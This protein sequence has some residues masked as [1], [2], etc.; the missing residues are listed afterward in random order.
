MRICIPGSPRT[1]GGPESFKRKL[2][3]GLSEFDISVT[4]D[5][6]EFPFDL[7]LVVS[8]TRHLLRLRNLKRQGVPIVHRLDGFHWYSRNLGVFSK[9]RWTNHARNWMMR[10][11]RDHLA[12]HVVYQSRFIENWWHDAHG[13]ARAQSSVIYNGVD[14]ERFF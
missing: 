1:I 2:T 3:Q 8:S 11:I 13:P 10:F 7:V 5:L 14:T 4:Y 6:D 12:D 9:P